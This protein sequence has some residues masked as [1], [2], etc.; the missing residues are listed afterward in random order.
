MQIAKLLS[1]EAILEELGTRLSQHRVDQSLTQAQ[2]ARQ[3]GV[4][5]RTVERIEAGASAQLSSVIRLLR[6]LD[7]LPGLERAI[8]AVVPGPLDLLN[9]KGKL[10]QRAVGSRATS[11]S[12]N[13]PD[14]P[15][16]WAD[17]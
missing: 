17:E 6:V 12:A 9:R 8:P 11:G 1:D 4:S 15:W 3:A 2:L 5:K 13:E 10:R 14:A 7:L 16:T